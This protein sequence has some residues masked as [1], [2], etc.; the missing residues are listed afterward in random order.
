MKDKVLETTHAEATPE[1]LSEE[2]VKAELKASQVAVH[3]SNSERLQTEPLLQLE[4]YSKLQTVLRVTAWIKRFLYNCRSKQRKVGEIT[5]EEISESEKIWIREAQINSF[6]RETKEL[7][8]GK[9]VHKDSKIRDFKPFLDEH[10]LI[11]VGGRLHQSD[12]SFTEQHPWL[13][14]G[15]H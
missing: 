3:L 14:A 1:V 8:T 5:A 15:P 2:E 9:D 13:L 4:K 7:K 11:C 12:L 10:G 6:E